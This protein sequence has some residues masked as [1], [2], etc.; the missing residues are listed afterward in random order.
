MNK[1]IVIVNESES[2]KINE[3]F[4]RKT[5]TRMVPVTINKKPTD[6]SIIPQGGIINR[7]F[8]K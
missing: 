1:A 3:S 2:P 6:I 8:I 7:L 5:F 4:N